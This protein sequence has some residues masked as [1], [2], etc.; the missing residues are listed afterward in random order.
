MTKKIKIIIIISSV[1]FLTI[2]F[3]S[4]IVYLIIKD[5]DYNKNA[6]IIILGDDYKVRNDVVYVD[7]DKSLYYDKK[8]YGTHSE[9][10]Y[11]SNDKKIY[12]D[13]NREMFY[14]SDDC[15]IYRKSHLEIANS[16]T[17]YV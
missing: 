11:Q 1:S 6:S 9:I 16:E 14:V 4:M 10:V 5:L 13:I 8:I 2:M 17:G 15:L 3:L 12:N 7:Y